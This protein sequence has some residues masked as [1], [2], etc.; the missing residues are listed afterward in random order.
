[1]KDKS[2]KAHQ[3]RRNGG[4]N[5]LALHYFCAAT[6]GIANIIYALFRQP[7]AVE[8]EPRDGEGRPIAHRAF[9][10]SGRLHFCTG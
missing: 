10:I 4:L 5:L 6:D 8:G 1:M 2:P 7:I 9:F 3:Q